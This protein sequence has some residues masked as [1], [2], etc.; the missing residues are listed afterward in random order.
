MR[1]KVR[2]SVAEDYVYDKY[3]YIKIKPSCVPQRHE[4]FVDGDVKGFIL[5]PDSKK[6][7]SMNHEVAEDYG[8]EF[9]SQEDDLI[10]FEI[11]Y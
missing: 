7:N 2:A 5:Q 3:D 10:T 8:I 11:F 1:F 6:L 4:L 9:I